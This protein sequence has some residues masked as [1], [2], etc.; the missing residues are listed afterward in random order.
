MTK[1]T[2]EIF[3]AGTHT[4]MDGKT[5]TFTKADLEATAAAYD[6]AVFSAPAVI[7][8]PKH[9]DPAYGWA[10][11]LRVEGD[12]LVA[13][14]DQV[15][16]AFAEIVNAGSYKKVSPW[17]YSPAAKNNPV[18]GCYYPRHIG[19]LGAAAPGCQGLAPVAFAEG[20]EAELVAFATDEELRPLIWLAR[21]V[22]RMYR[23]MRD[24]IIEDKGLEEANKVIPEWEADAPAEIAAQLDAALSAPRTAF[25]EGDA[26]PVSDAEIA[27]AELASREE[28]LAAREA[29]VATQEAAFAEGQR[30]DR[31]QEDD[32]FLDGLIAA[33]R[34]APGHKAEVAVFCAALG[35]GEAIAFAEGGEAEDPRARFKA[36]L[37]KHLGQS[38]HLDEVA[39]AEGLRFAEG[40]SQADLEAAIDA[41]MTSAAAAGHPISAAE[42]SRRAKSRR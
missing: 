33:G 34:L 28:A 5:Y 7:G 10:T 41:E 38:I 19:F 8:H 4:A 42:A 29:A 35:D 20:D 9:D 25:A 13:D 27:A 40:Q 12:V 32:A 21:G 14:L 26:P 3:R 16:P 6:P 17:F 31:V 15:N 36:F 1:K 11:A 39:G 24:Q 22:A 2:I 23:R 18:P 30:Q 37:D